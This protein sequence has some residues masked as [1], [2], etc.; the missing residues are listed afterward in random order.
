[1]RHLCFRIS[2]LVT[3]VPFVFACESG[4]LQGAKAEVKDT[5]IRLDLPPVPE[6]TMPSPHSDG[7]HSVREMRLKGRKLFGTEQKVRGFITWKYDC[8]AALL[9]PEFTKKQIQALIAK[10]PSRCTRPHFYIGDSPDTP[11]EKS[12]W[13]VEVPRKLRKD[14]TRKLSRAERRRLPRPPRVRIGDEV[15][16]TGTWDRSSP[17]G[18]ANSDGLLV[19]QKM[20]TLAK[21]GSVDIEFEDDGS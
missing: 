10:D 8:V 18:F 3:L 14:E 15:S 11:P 12:L 16:V 4:G 2:V 20:K 1:M 9:T 7:T 13:V 21:A 6:F 19:Y 5:T 17:A